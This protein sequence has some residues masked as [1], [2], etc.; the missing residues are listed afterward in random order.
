LTNELDHPHMK[1]STF[2]SRTLTEH[3]SVDSMFYYLLL[4]EIFTELDFY[5]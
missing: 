1:Y 2:A 4:K 5:E 3:Q